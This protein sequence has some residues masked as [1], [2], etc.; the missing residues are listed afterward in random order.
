MKKKSLLAILCVGL[1]AVVSVFGTV[2]YLT[3]TDSAVNTFTMGKVDITLDEAK[4][5]KNGQPI[6]DKGGNPVDRVQGNEYHLV[7]GQTYIKDPTITVKA[8]S[9]ESYVRMMVT[10]N[11]AKEL[12]E[13]FAPDGAELTT[14]FNGY[15]S[16][17]WVYKEANQDTD[18]NTI[19]YEFRY[20]KTVLGGDED[21]KLEAL[22]ESFTLPGNITGD[23]LEKLEKIEMTVSGHAVQATGFTDED[24]AWSAFDEQMGSYS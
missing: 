7:P 16:E 2:A 17:V 19:T 11:C 13:I 10:I 23:E 6:L 9:E 24:A 15:D 8:G 22:F 3:D 4:V 14:I 21:I 18:A 20:C 12:D 1:V 5:D